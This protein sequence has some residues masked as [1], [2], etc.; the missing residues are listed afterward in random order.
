MA[1]AFPPN[2]PTSYRP[3]RTST[4]SNQVTFAGE[5]I[6]VTAGQ[7]TVGA[8]FGGVRVPPGAEIIGVVTSGP[9]GVTLEVG[10][11]GD[12][13]RLQ[14]GAA[15]GTVNQAIAATGLGYKYPAETLIQ[16]RVSA[17]A[18]ATGGTLRYGVHYVSQ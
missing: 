1:Q 4:D 13:D 12:T 14:T 7:Q 15:S 9:T 2:D 3:P 11:A 17:A 5:T 16:V 6:T 8:L 18:G 10:D